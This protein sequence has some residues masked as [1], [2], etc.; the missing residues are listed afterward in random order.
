MAVGT[1]VAMAAVVAGCGSSSGGSSSTSGTGSGGSAA[2]QT[3]MVK[4]VSGVGSVLVDGTGAALYTPAQEAGGKVLCSGTCTSIWKPLAPGSGTPTAAQGVGKLAVVTRPDG[5]R[6]VTVDGKPLYTFAQDTPGK[7]TGN[8][9][10]DT[11]GSRHFT[12]HAVLASGK[13]AS[14][15]GGSTGSGSSAPSGPGYSDGY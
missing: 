12:W 5:S 10:T 2:T 6:Q 7:V 1:A 3:V 15:S 14:S 11:F 9:A 4:N 8:G 13:A